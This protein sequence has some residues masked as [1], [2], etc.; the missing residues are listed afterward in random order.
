LR[1]P[2]FFENEGSYP[3]ACASDFPAAD[4][5]E[6]LPAVRIVTTTEIRRPIGEVFNFL[7]TPANW[8][9][10]HPSSIRVTGASDHSLDVGEQVTEEFHVA[11][12]YGTA[13]WQVRE[14]QAPHRWVIEGATENGNRATLTYTLTET[15]Q[16]DGDV[17]R[18]ERELVLTNVST[19]P[20]GALAMFQRQVEAESTEALR[21]LKRLVEAQT[22]LD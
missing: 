22:P 11:G 10:W 4:V 16:A 14:R 15:E 9:R 1:F 20:A 3:D 18:F 7:T 17:T 12:Q 2:L 6:E 19:V 21:R 8:P 5:L 13:V